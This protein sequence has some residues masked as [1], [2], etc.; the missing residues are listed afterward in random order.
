MNPGLPSPV[1]AGAGR[2]FRFEHSDAMEGAAGLCF[3]DRHLIQVA[4]G[5]RPIEETDTVLHEVFH[6]L[7]YCQGREYAG[8]T[9]E[10]FVRALATGF[11]GLLQDNPEF[12]QWLSVR[13]P[14]KTL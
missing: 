7:L 2:V 11:T 8:R 5:Q 6:A 13:F 12:L 3:F 14:H 10:T 9:E 4:P 1:K